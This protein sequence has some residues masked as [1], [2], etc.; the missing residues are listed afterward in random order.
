MKSSYLRIMRA[1]NRGVGV[2]LSASE[3]I[4]MSKDH[5]IFALAQNDEEDVRSDQRRSK[6]E[7]DS[8]YAKRMLQLCI[9]GHLRCEHDD[10]GRCLKIVFPSGASLKGRQ[11]ECG[12]SHRTE[13]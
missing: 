5:A 11:C 12:S 2:R 13:D 4:A 7:P 8:V 6:L 10:W 3:V 1:A 9:C